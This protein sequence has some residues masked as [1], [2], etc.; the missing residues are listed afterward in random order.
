MHITIADGID[1]HTF[2]LQGDLV[3]D[4][5]QHALTIVM[6][7]GSAERLSV[8]LGAYGL[9]ASGDTVF[10][11]D[12]SEHSGLT[13]SLVDLGVVE[14]V[15]A[16]NVG[17]FNLRAYEV[18]PLSGGTRLMRLLAPALAAEAATASE[19]RS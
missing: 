5:E 4:S 13:R 12:W 15:G 6:P 9:Q 3:H 17:Q 14:V 11:K 19:A 18:R 7:D 8:N 16:C 2:G 1:L 10:I